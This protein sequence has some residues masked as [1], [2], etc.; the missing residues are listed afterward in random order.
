[1][2]HEVTSRLHGK[3]DIFRLASRLQLFVLKIE[4]S[5]HASGYILFVRLLCRIAKISRWRPLL[6]QPLQ[7]SYCCKT[8]H[9]DPIH[10]NMGPDSLRDH[11]TS[12]PTHHITSR[13]DHHRM[14][15]ESHR[16]YNTILHQN[17]ANDISC[18][19]KDLLHTDIHTRWI[20]FDIPAS[21][22]R[23]CPAPPPTR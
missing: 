9:V 13:M 1:M 11:Y 21:P 14:K 17:A 10:G 4:T 19:Q 18:R 22:P 23:R 20:P 2:A 8:S 5:V 12:Y 7:L 3:M 16:N 15:L 6:A